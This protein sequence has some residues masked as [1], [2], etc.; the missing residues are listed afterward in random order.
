MSE[1]YYLTDEVLGADKKTHVTE[2]RD[3]KQ[4]A[5]NRTVAICYDHLIAVKLCEFLNW[6]DQDESRKAKR[7]ANKLHAQR[8]RPTDL[9]QADPVDNESNPAAGDQQLVAG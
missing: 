3:H 7:E 8:R 1:R 4:S 6:S 5:G 9:H 2:I